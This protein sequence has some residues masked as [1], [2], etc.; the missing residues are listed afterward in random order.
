MDCS[1]P[2]SLVHGIFQA[3][4]LEWVAIS[5]S[6]GSSQPRDWT[7]ISPI[8]RR[9]FTIWATREALLWM[10]A[11]KKILTHS[12]PE[13]GHSRRDLQ[14][15]SLFTL[16]PQLLPLSSIKKLAF[17]PWQVG[18]FETLVC[19]LLGHLAF[20]IKSYSLSQHLVSDTLAFHAERRARLDSVTLN[21]ICLLELEWS[22]RWFKMSKSHI[23]GLLWI[24]IWTSGTSEVGT[25]CSLLSVFYQNWWVNAIIL[26][27]EQ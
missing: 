16:F 23:N 9:G 5:F 1:P 20:P 21:E 10:A 27:V 15:N 4:V 8:V 2:G 14:D 24:V 13:V 12:L 19:Y 3:R 6:R 18:Y 22:V 17:R 25:F 7:Q 11:K 26:S